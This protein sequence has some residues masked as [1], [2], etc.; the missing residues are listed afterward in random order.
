MKD[1]GMRLTVRFCKM[2]L[3][4]PSLNHKKREICKLA[5]TND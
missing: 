4:R 3:L 2:P 5:F 1:L